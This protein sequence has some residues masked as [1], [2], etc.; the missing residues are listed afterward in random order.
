MR[1]DAIEDRGVGAQEI[2]RS[3]AAAAAA[4]A[5]PRRRLAQADRVAA[6]AGIGYAVAHQAAAHHADLGATLIVA[7]V[8]RIQYSA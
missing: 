5:A 3:S 8:P 1:R 6:G 4:R 2:R 7:G